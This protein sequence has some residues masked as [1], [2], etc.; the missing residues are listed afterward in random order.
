MD[1]EAHCL[2]D[3]FLQG[4]TCRETLSLFQEL[5]HH[6]HLDPTDYRNF[7]QKLK[8]SLNYWKAKALWVKLDKRASHNDYEQGRACA[9][10]KCL[11][12]GAGPCGLRAA[13][14]LVFLGA[15]VLVVE[16]RDSFSRNNVLHLW[17]FTIHDLR[18]LGAKKFYGKFCSG[19]LDHISIRQLQLILL[20]VA[21]ILGVEVHVNVEY[22]GFRE[23]PKDQ[24][25]KGIGWRADLLPAGHPVSE[26]EFDVFVSAGGGKYV[27]EGFKKKEMRGKLAIGITANF[28]NHNSTAEAK[29]EE[30]SGVA[31]LYNQKFFQQLRK[32]TGIDLENIVYYKDDTHYFVMTAKKQS[33]LKYGVI[34]QDKQDAD[35]LLS[36]QNVSSE[37][38]LRYAREAANFSTKYQLPNLEFATNHR[39][40]PD[41][42]MF[43]FTCMYRSEFAALVKERHGHRLLVALVGDCLVEPFWPL[44]TGIARGFLA[45]F[46]TAWLVRKWGMGI[47]PVELLAERESIY[48]LLSQTTPGNTNKNI[49]RY[50][51]DPVTR[52]P[53]LNLSYF[54]P[55]QVQHLYD[56]GGTTDVEKETKQTKGKMLRNDSV[57]G[58]EE[59][60]S[61]C[62][63][64]TEGY[65]N[66]KVVDLTTSWKSGLALCALIHRFRPDLINFESLKENSV[67]ENN[68]LAFNITE[69]EFGISPIMTGREMAAVS[70][71]DKI[72][73]VMY[74]TQFNEFFKDLSPELQDVTKKKIMTLST[75]KSALLFLSNLRKNVANKRSS[76]EKEDFEDESETKRRRDSFASDAEPGTLLKKGLNEA[77]VGQS[78]IH[79]PWNKSSNAHAEQPQEKPNEA[80]AEAK[81]EGFFRQAEGPSSSE[82]CYFCKERVYVVERLSADGQFF[83]RGC[84]TCHQCGT[85]LR[86]G[87]YAFDSKDGKFYCMPHYTSLLGSNQNEREE[88]APIQKK[89]FPDGEMV[90]DCAVERIGD[91]IQGTEA[92]TGKDEDSDYEEALDGQMDNENQQEEG[93]DQCDEETELAGKYQEE[94][95]DE[96][97]Q[98]ERE[99]EEQGEEGSNQYNEET[100]LTEKGL[101]EC[102]EPNRV[103]VMRHLTSPGRSPSQ[104][105]DQAFLSHTVG[106]HQWSSNGKS[107]SYGS[108][109]DSIFTAGSGKN[110]MDYKNIIEPPNGAYN[111]GSEGPP[112]PATN[113][114][115]PYLSDTNVISSIFVELPPVLL[116]NVVP[117]GNI[118]EINAERVGVS[119]MRQSSTTDKTFIPSLE[120]SEAHTTE[121]SPSH[122]AKPLH[123]EDANIEESVEDAE[124][125]SESSV[126]PKELSSANVDLIIDKEKDNGNVSMKKLSLSATQRCKLT[127][128]S[129]TSDSDSESQEDGTQP[130]IQSDDKIPSEASKILPL[131]PA[132]SIGAEFGDSGQ[133]WQVPD[134][135]SQVLRTGNNRSN[136]EQERKSQVYW[137]SPCP[138]LKD[139][140]S[141]NASQ[142]LHTKSELELPKVKTTGDLEH[143]E[144]PAEK[145][146]ASE[147]S[148]K[149]KSKLSPFSKVLSRI[150]K[151]G[152]KNKEHVNS[153]PRLPKAEIP[154][155]QVS[156]AP[157]KE[158][159]YCNLSDNGQSEEDEEEEDSFSEDELESNTEPP[160]KTKLSP[161]ESAARRETWRLRTFERHAKQEIMSRFLKAQMIQRRLEEIEQMFHELEQRGI[162]LEQEMRMSK[163]EQPQLM[164]SWIMLVQDKNQLLSEESELMISATEDR[165]GLSGGGEDLQGNDRGGQDEGQIGHIP[166]ATET[167]GAR[168]VCSAGAWSCSKGPLRRCHHHLDMTI[169]H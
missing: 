162:H 34:D 166:G 133:E 49:S 156:P 45:A 25:E 63:Q 127:R 129:V 110:S 123:L 117:L 107:I 32:D 103:P 163:R 141:P 27:P 50:S 121:S 155:I 30:I 72:S 83:H 137:D 41:V 99:D 36:M 80:T 40:E 134:N 87:N 64:H 142:P 119:Q 161:E 130:S 22:K 52:Y 10:T 75:A 101:Y 54:K 18:A 146:L 24:K 11:V 104:D 38:L 165:E 92:A 19:S 37:S 47:A 118:A 9:G 58:Y 20:K 124:R 152:K 5:C 113:Q 29:V 73:M 143:G 28:V 149:S 125:E 21:L 51:I 84:F 91:H 114:S 95:I 13:I 157:Q 16:K 15:R 109:I 102:T 70:S 66:V 69:K 6:L 14:E 138:D 120:I 93:S 48:Q 74:L 33:L 86:F 44:G 106:E 126:L 81:R 90:L 79:S 148:N 7:Y 154:A 26:Y 68:Q 35:S 56:V 132:T 96:G 128:L 158:V 139:K 39:G 115:T 147:T 60:L 65:K 55:H 151:R 82:V 116:D 53:N 12:L 136:K 112:S 168:T 43:D 3:K 131:I 105:M 144:K 167:S 94:G 59:L 2:F 135:S 76:L 31:Y 8:G 150:S 46:D 159:K 89:D 164:Q 62:Q 153:A 169:A 71:P 61:W 23:P 57:G 85:T 97:L 140:S 122:S 160:I 88:T 17:P 145:D 108:S 111:N 77:F 67:A 100:K 98:E 1:N 4:K 42:A 78:S